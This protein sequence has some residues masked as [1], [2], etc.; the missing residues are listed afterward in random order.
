MDFS[1]GLWNDRCGTMHGVKEEETKIKKSK[2]VQQVKNNY[3]NKDKVSKDVY[4]LVYEQV[5][6]L[7]M[8]TA[9]YLAKWLATYRLSAV[10]KK[11]GVEKKKGRKGRKDK[12]YDRGSARVPKYSVSHK[13]WEL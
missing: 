2:I 12:Q 3:K 1:L 5:G 10:R 11:R 7:C 6:V 9:Q 8:K 13:N 4:H